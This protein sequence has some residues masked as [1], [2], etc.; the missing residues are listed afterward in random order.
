MEDKTYTPSEEIANLYE[1]LSK[2]QKEIRLISKNSKKSIMSIDSLTEEIKENKD[3]S[4]KLKKELEE[5]K[6]KEVRIY[7]KIIIILDQID[8]MYKFAKQL[9]NQE[10]IDCLNVIKKSIRK[11]ISEID[12]I[13]IRAYG[14]LFNA[15]IHKCVGIEEDNT[16]EDNEI[17]SVIENG[18]TLNG[19][20][21]RPASVI[22]SKNMKE[23]ETDNEQNNRD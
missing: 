3:Q 9:E 17:I 10:F 15:E 7:K 11:E 18:Y 12:L 21:L 19:K 2:V 8:N 14:E 1:A 20:V 13:E 23:G 4:F 22:I 5:T 16:K 6:F